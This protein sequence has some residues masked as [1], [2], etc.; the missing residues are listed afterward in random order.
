MTIL[1]DL[2]SEF[3]KLRNDLLRLADR[4]A[5]LPEEVREKYSRAEVQ[6]MFGWSHG[7]EIMN[8]VSFRR[9]FWDWF[10]GR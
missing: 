3:P 6:Y 8:G 4:F 9:S 7:K 2:P 5:S 10:V 1:A